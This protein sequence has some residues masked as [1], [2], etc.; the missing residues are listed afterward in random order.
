MCGARFG[1]K[2]GIRL[3]MFIQHVQPCKA[4]LDLLVAGAGP[5]HLSCK[6]DIHAGCERAVAVVVVGVFARISVPKLQPHSDIFVRAFCLTIG[7][8]FHHVPLSSPGFR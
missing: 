1:F 6:T 8:S 5:L 4:H 2:S 7:T 3:N